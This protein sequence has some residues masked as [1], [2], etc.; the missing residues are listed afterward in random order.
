MESRSKGTGLENPRVIDG[1]ILLLHVQGNIQSLV[2]AVA[3][4]ATDITKTDWKL[5]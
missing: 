5:S 4:K 1:N 2:Y 3:N